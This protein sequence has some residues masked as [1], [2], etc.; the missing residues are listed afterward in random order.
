MSG[1]ISRGY[2]KFQQRQANEACLGA[3]YTD[4]QHCE[5]LGELFSF[6]TEEET[7]VLEPSAGNGL[8]VKLVTGA[9]DNP[10]VRIFAVE[11]NDEVANTL[12][13]DASMECVL[14]ADFTSD[15]IISNKVFSFCF[16]NPPYMDE[17]EFERIRS[18]NKTKERTE[19]VFLEK[20]T[21]YLKANGII[22]WVIPHRVFMENTYTSFW[23]SRYETLGI[24]KFHDK[25]YEKW[26]QIALIGRK[27]ACTVAPTKEQREAFQSRCALNLLDYVPKKG[28]FTGEKI[29]VMPSSCNSISN[30]KAKTFNAVEAQDFVTENPSVLVSLDE[31]IA[32]ST[33][34]KEY[35]PA[36]DY[37]PP[38]RLSN[39]N[40]A[41]LTACGIGSG[42]VGSSEERNL[43]LQR[44]SVTVTEEQVI[45][46]TGDKAV[47]KVKSHSTTNI[48]LLESDGEFKDLCKRDSRD[49]EYEEEEG[50]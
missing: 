43:H 15:V 46:K 33:G 11:L 37:R 2:N 3:Y 12:K 38:K 7:T 5:W 24:Y 18:F 4:P 20:V 9:E 23:M 42:Y 36:R 1:V 6:S 44:G 40:L 13:E 22:C 26:G 17:L 47:L 50:A 32:K 39:Q 30:F 21:N 29:A 27:R 8:A 45:E 14:K 41:L 34:I 48:T 19:K 25:E 10:K 31:A 28:E 35:N 49:T 16:G